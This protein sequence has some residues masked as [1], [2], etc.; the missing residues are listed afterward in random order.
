MEKL[1]PNKFG[2]EKLK[3][4]TSQKTG[5][6]Y[7]FKTIGFVS[8][9]YPDRWYNINYNDSNPLEL[10]KTH[11]LEVKSREYNGKTYWDAKLPQQGGRG[12]ISSVEYQTILRDMQ[13]IK[14]DT[15]IIIGLLKKNAAGYDYP[16]SP[17]EPTL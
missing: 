2:E 14:T 9:E 17:E 10:G 12:G 11:E 5:K 7:S 4:G 8:N 13:A 3:S 1:T 6:P 15:Q 16:E